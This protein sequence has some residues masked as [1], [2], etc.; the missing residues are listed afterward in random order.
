MAPGGGLP[1]AGQVGAVIEPQSAVLLA[2]KCHAAAA[3]RDIERRGDQLL[4]DVAAAAS[5]LVFGNGGIAFPVARH[6]ARIDRGGGRM[7]EPRGADDAQRQSALL[8]LFPEQ[9]KLVPAARGAVA[10]GHAGPVAEHADPGFHARM[11]GAGRARTVGDLRIGIVGLDQ[12]DIVEGLER[13]DVFLA[14]L[15]LLLPRID[16]RGGDGGNPHAVADEQDDVL[17][18]ARGLRFAGSRGSARLVGIIVIVGGGAATQGQRRGADGQAER[19]DGHA[20][21]PGRFGGAIYHGGTR[22]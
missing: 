21:S 2:I 22:R 14:A 19:A 6:A 20:M 5:A 18:L 7:R 10:L 4:R 11:H 16:P 8:H 12:R 17:R 3:Q 13:Q 9:A 15:P 1:V